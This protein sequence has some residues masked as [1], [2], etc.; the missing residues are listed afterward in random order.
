MKRRKKPTKKKPVKKRKNVKRRKKPVLSQY[1]YRR[2]YGYGADYA[3][4]WDYDATKARMLC[5]NCYGQFYIWTYDKFKVFNWFCQDCRKQVSPNKWSLIT[6]FHK[7]MEEARFRKRNPVSL[8]HGD[9]LGFTNSMFR[10]VR[11]KA[12]RDVVIKTIKLAIDLSKY[13]DP[14]ILGNLL[15]RY[16]RVVGVQAKKRNG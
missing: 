10:C 4:D 6:K 9:V 13:A 7:Y 11:G 3:E 16:D 14:I 8:Q 2:H 1:V 12:S 15:D 5:I